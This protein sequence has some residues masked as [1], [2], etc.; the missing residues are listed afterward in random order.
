MARWDPAPS[1]IRSSSGRLGGGSLSVISNHILTVRAL[2]R[3][4]R[5]NGRWVA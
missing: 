5:G 4:D 3:S 1:P 2:A